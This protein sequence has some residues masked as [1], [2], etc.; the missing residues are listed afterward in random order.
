[1]AN[2][3]PY[4]NLNPDPNPNLNPNR[5]PNPNPNSNCNPNPNRNPNSLI[6]SSEDKIG[7]VNVSAK[8]ALKKASLLSG[9]A[10]FSDYLCFHTVNTHA[11]HLC[12]KFVE[13][14][15]DFHETVLKGTTEIRPR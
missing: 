1:V 2:P 3:N 11:P 14:H 6:G 4:P 15:F 13:A 9:S 10:A 7:D 8:E 5:N 12:N